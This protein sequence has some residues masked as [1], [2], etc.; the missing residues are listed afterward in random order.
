LSLNKQKAVFE[1]IP[2]TTSCASPECAQKPSLP[3]T[4]F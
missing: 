1:K 2:Q 3:F 4:L